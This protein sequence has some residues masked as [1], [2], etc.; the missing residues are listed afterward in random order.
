[1]IGH[2]DLRSVGNYN[3]RLRNSSVTQLF[4]FLDKILN[5]ERNSVSD[6]VG[7]ILMKNSRRKL[8]KREFSIIIDNS[9]TGVCSA[10]KTNYYVAVVREDVGD[11]SLALVAPV[12]AYYCFNHKILS[13]YLLTKNLIL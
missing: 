3:V 11:F 4:H 7:D 5:A 1:M 8:M 6:H 9:M 2:Y 13:P 12:R 10:L